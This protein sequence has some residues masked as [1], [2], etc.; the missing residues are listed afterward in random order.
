M[1]IPDTAVND[2]IT[3]QIEQQVAEGRQLGVQVCAYRH[4]ERIVDTWAGTVGPGDDRPVGPD[5]LF[6]SF[7]TTKGVAATALHILVDRGV[8]DPS[9]P[10]AEYWPEFAA[11]GKGHVTVTQAVSHLAGLHTTPVPNTREHVVDWQKGVDYVANLEPAWEPGKETGYHAITFGWI[12][13]GIVEAASG[14]HI[15]EVIREDVAKPLGIEDE[16]FVG[17]PDGVEDRLTKLQTPETPREMPVEI[18]PD[19]DFFKAM[20]AR[21]DVNYNELDVRKACLPSANG[22]FTARALARMYAALAFGGAL[23]GVQLM[24]PER[25]Q[26]MSAVVT[27]DMDRVIMRPMPKGTGYFLGGAVEGVVGSMGPRET[28]FGHPGAGGSIA[29]ADPEAGLSVAVTLNKMQ[30]SLQGEGPTF[31][32][33]DAIRDELAVNT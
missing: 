24:S 15:R 32:I 13:G 28:A 12:I 21:T 14:R 17:I 31:E 26:A 2:R 8:I 4:G 33:C 5:T 30:N 3:K 9:A 19:H 11:K 22:H 1:G 29:F 10:V 18:P 7:S 25:I 23:D 16:M 27:R 20:P 6:S